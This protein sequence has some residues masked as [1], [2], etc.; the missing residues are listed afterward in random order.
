MTRALHLLGYDADLQSRH[1]SRVLCEASRGAG[2]GEVVARTIGR[3]G[4]YSRLLRA[5]IGLRRE[6]AAFDLVH[7]WDEQSLAAAVFAGARRI[8]FTAPP[9]LRRR[10]L[11][12]LRFVMRFRDVRI[13]CSTPT[14]HRAYVETGIPDD[15]CVLIRPAVASPPTRPTTERAEIRR[16]LGLR[17][18]DFVLI[19]P[20]ESTRAAAHER[21]VWTG[22]ILHVTD[23]RYRALLWG[24]GSHVDAAAGLGRKLRQPGLVVVAERVLGR[25]VEFDELLPAADAMLVS[26]RGPVPTLPVA[27]AMTAGVPVVAVERPEFA[28][29]LVDGVTAFSVPTF[30]PRLLAQRVLDMRGDVHATQSVTETARERARR[31]MPS[32]PFILSYRTLYA[33]AGSAPAPSGSLS[34]CAR[35]G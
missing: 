15:R 10:T 3:A 33:M 17:D 31:L 32:E 35:P 25:P 23:E 34:T 26:P 7:A 20:G 21:A 24:H 14:Q 18:D 22:S 16:R 27:M 8:V 5:V 2:W 30:S 19:A 12:R 28:E 13:A 1:G 29:L 4:K 6:V 11:D 9:V